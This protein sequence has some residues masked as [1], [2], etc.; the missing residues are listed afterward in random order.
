MIL[1]LTKGI[2]II[3]LFTTL[4]TCTRSAYVDDPDTLLPQIPVEPKES[5]ITPE[6]KT[7]VVDSDQAI[8]SMTE[9]S[10]EAEY[11]ISYSVAFLAD[12]EILNVRSGPGVTFEIVAS[13][14]PNDHGL[15]TT[16]KIESVDN[17][18]WRELYIDDGVGWVSGAFLT[19]EKSATE[20]CND[21]QIGVLLDE[22]TNV[23]RNKDGSSLSNLVSPIHGVT[24][25]HNLW[26]PPVN[27]E[28]PQKIQQIFTSDETYDWGYQDGS[29]DPI[30]GSFKDVI[31]P[32]LED[33]LL[34]NHSRHC[35][36][37]E[38]GVATG[39]TAGYVF[40]PYDYSSF[41]Y[42][43]MFRQ[44]P[45]NEELDWRTWVAGIEYVDGKPYIVVLI[46]FY[47]EI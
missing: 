7:E 6:V 26:N 42:I 31:L 41:N 45:Q 30:V 39:S 29:G 15:R 24:I 44:A 21:P 10:D 16:G 3:V 33:V 5:A 28:N 46:Q 11:S 32:R 22:F 4:T 43:A 1:Q 25:H 27:L 19:E 17:I 8:P 36:V 37:L 35:N 9:S 2:F 47:W 40:W 13:L 18:P 38:R 14:N 34:V 23:I 12:G 20:V